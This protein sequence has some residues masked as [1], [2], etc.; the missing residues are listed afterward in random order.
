MKPMHIQNTPIISLLC[1]F[2]DI[3]NSLSQNYEHL[4]QKIFKTNALDI[5]QVIS[6]ITEL[7]IS[8]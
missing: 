4:N 6:F 1:C 2:V 7:K 8:I 5:N 3:E